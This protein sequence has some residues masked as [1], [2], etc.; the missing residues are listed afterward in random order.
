MTDEQVVRFV[1]QEV[2][3]GTDQ[4]TIVTKLLQ[5]GV[6]ADQMRRIKKKYD[7]EQSQLGAVDLTGS[8]EV[9]SGSSRMRTAKEKAAD[10]AQK[11]KGFMI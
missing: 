6:S 11:R 8:T 10:E 7:A 2:E 9:K 3:K 5:K 1:K 4:Q